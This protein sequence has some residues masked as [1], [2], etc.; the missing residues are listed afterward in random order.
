MIGVIPFILKTQ[1]KARSNLCSRTNKKYKDTRDSSLSNKKKLISRKQISIW[2]SAIRPSAWYTI[3][4]EEGV[5][6]TRYQN[7]SNLKINYN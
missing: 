5:H 7:G 1:F 4:Q 2:E 3:M 6:T